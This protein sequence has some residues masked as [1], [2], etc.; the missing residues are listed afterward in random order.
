MLTYRLAQAPGFGQGEES[1]A[2]LAAAPD[3]NQ[4]V[5]FGCQSSI[6]RIVP[7]RV[8]S[9]GPKDPHV[10]GVVD[11]YGKRVRVFKRPV[12]AEDARRGRQEKLESQ[13][14]VTGR[15]RGPQIDAALAAAEYQQVWA[16]LGQ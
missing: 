10:F 4:E 6:A 8:G 2:V 12:G 11:R 9:A 5:T 7:G 15:G 16:K 14:G 3:D 13:P 1:P